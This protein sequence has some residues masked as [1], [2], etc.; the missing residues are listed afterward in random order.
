MKKLIQFILLS[1]AVSCSVIPGPEYGGRVT[2]KVG[3]R[4]GTGTKATVEGSAAENTVTSLQVFIFKK[5]GDEFVYESSAMGSGSSLT[6]SVTDGEKRILAL[7]NEQTDYTS[8]TTENGVLALGNMLSDNTPSGFLMSGAAGY[9]VSPTRNS[10]SIPVS[11]VASRIHL[12]KITNSLGAGLGDKD[13]KLKRVYLTGAASMSD[14]S[15]KDDGDSFYATKAI[16]ALLDKDGAAVGDDEKQKVNALLYDGSGSGIIPR[17][18]GTDADIFLYTY[19][20]NGETVRTHMVAELEIDGRNYTYPVELETIGRNCTYEI[21]ELNIKSLG[22][23]SNGDDII[24]D[25]EDDPIVS[26][27]A[28]FGIEVQPWTV[29]PVSNE[30][31]GSYTI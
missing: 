24:D 16:G 11:R 30:D 29:V 13:V 4:P 14:Y 2:L 5:A 19:P 7:V 26:E 18:G 12:K 23:H 21:N 20:N 1:A 8:V 17:G 25:G 3:I 22:N 10:V 31:D 28:T 27:T 15:G 6:V 9:D